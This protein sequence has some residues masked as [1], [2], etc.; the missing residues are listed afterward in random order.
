MLLVYTV[1]NMECV[2][3]YRDHLLLGLTGRDQQ[4]DKSFS[5][6]EEEREGQRK[7][8]LFCLESEGCHFL[9][10][11]RSQKSWEETLVGK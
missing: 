10:R 1:L 6:D 11:N 4:L 7:R 9:G 5:P 3:W 2:L 8:E